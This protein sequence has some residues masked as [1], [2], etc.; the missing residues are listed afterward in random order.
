ML[1]V[2]FFVPLALWYTVGQLVV[3][4]LSWASFR[5]GLKNDVTPLLFLGAIV[6]VKL[7]VTVAMLHSVREGLPAVRARRL[8]DDFAPWRGEESESL[9]G[10]VSRSLFPFLIFYLAWGVLAEDARAFSSSNASRGLAEGGLE[11]GVQGLGQAIAV[12][13]HV[14]LAIGLAVAFFVLKTVTERWLLPRYPR[15]M[16]ILIAVFEIYW[17]LFA[18]FTITRGLRA[19]ASWITSRTAWEGSVGRIPDIPVMGDALSWVFDDLVSMFN[20]GVVLALIW[21][22][23][24]GVVLGAHLNDEENLLRRSERLRAAFA[25]M[26]GLRAVPAEAMEQV[27]Q[28]LLR[29]KWVPAVNGIRLIRYA[30]IP[31]FAVFSV[32]YAAVS[33]LDELGRR[34]VHVL[35]GAESPAWWGPRLTIVGFAVGLVV[36]MLRICLLAAAFDLVVARA[37][38]RLRRAAAAPPQGSPWRWSPAGSPGAVPAYAGAPS[39]G[40]PYTLPPPLHAQPYGASPAPPGAPGWPQGPLPGPPPG[41]PAG[42]PY[43]GPPSPG[44]PPAGSMP[45]APPPASPAP[46]PGPPPP[47]PPPPSGPPAWPP[48][49]PPPG[50]PQGPPSGPPGPTAPTAPASPPADPAAGSPHGPSGESA[51]SSSP[52]SPASP[53]AADGAPEDG[54]EG[55]APPKAD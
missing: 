42:P 51:P 48:Q 3:W 52:A 55:S 20:D 10:A 18:L 4:G 34:G 50:P 15:I 6:I 19:I 8:D 21:L 53:P 25:R 49:G 28:T 47:E 38:D 27:T 14:P 37:A 1:A 41:P 26:R 12:E 17:A 11:G 39:A 33:V 45:P 35:L 46:P 22:I 32:F 44:W 29:E 31:A 13:E 36:E 54:S 2:R 30:G 7:I 16:G 40:A 9:L 23:I 43:P 5:L 24:A